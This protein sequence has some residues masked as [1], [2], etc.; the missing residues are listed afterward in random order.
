MKKILVTGAAGF[1]GF[2]TTKKLIDLGYEVI[3]LDNI[4]DYYD[5]NLKYDRLKELGIDRNKAEIQEKRVQSRSELFVKIREGKRIRESQIV[6]KY[7]NKTINELPLGL[8]QNIKKRNLFDEALKIMGRDD[9]IVWAKLSNKDFLTKTNDIIVS[10]NIKKISDLPSGLKKHMSKMKLENDVKKLLEN[11]GWKKRITL[12]DKTDEFL[13]N[14]TKEISI[15]NNYI[16]LAGLDNNHSALIKEL[17]DRNLIDDFLIIMNWKK[18]NIIPSDDDE[19]L[20]YTNNYILYHKCKLISK[21]PASL[22]RKLRD[23]YLL[24]YIKFDKKRISW[25]KFDDE[26]LINKT[27]EYIKINDCKQ[28]SDFPAGL[29]DHLRK[30]KL[31]QKLYESIGW[32][33]QK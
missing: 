18:R 2:H 20:E 14:Y 11:N 3:G 24:Q 17:R 12:Y 6:D 26:E 31:V 9:R 15:S 10:D 33:H 13:L 16:N 5:I 22:Y 32:N 25:Y 23:R 8:L 27:I 19:L 4:N 30:R 1:I 28:I 21:L 7:K 29:Q